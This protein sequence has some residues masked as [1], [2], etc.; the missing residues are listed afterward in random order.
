MVNLLAGER[1]QVK[2]Y[3]VYNEGSK[4]MLPSANFTSNNI[5]VAKADE[6]GWIIAGVAGN[7][8]VNVVYSEGNNTKTA[9]IP[10][11]VTGKI[12]HVPGGGVYV[13]E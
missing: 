13:S 11:S 5:S 12:V 8:T 10:V 9:T 2:I 4:K 1:Q 3:A 6:L 7:T